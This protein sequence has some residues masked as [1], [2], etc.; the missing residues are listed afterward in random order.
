[1]KPAARRALRPR[2]KD[3]GGSGRK[4]RIK[5][6]WQSGG[7][8]KA[9]P[10]EGSEWSAKWGPG[11]RERDNECEEVRAEIGTVPRGWYRAA[12][13]EAHTEGLPNG[14]PEG[15]VSTRVPGLDRVQSKE[16]WK[17]RGTRGSIPFTVSLM[18]EIMIHSLAVLLRVLAQV[19]ATDRRGSCTRSRMSQ[20]GQ[21]RSACCYNI[22]RPHA[23]TLKMFLQVYI[24]GRAQ[25]CSHQRC[26]S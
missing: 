23:S 24:K 26:L 11:E 2:N 10:G 4:A 25:A 18:A 5:G 16:R 15:M 19:A 6:Q 7:R 17:P 1:M 13:Q 14:L 20:E 12:F 8:E 22:P 3:I 9:V 21:G